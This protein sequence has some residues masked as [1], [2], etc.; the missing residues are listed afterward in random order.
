MEKILFHI[1]K[2]LLCEL[3]KSTL[4]K[5]IERNENNELVQ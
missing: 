2:S 4:L 5:V 3:W 1:M